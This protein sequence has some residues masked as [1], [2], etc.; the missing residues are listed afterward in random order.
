M[1]PDAQISLRVGAVWSESL[2][3]ARVMRLI[4]VWNGSFVLILINVRLSHT[5]K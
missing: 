4:S 5:E 3:G 1:A 2:T